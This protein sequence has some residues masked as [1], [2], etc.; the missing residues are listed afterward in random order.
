[1]RKKGKIALICCVAAVPLILIAAFLLLVLPYINA[2]SSM[3]EGASLSLLRVQSGDY[4][5]SW[6]E[7]EGAAYYGVSLGGEDDNSEPTAESHTLLAGL[8]ESECTITVTPYGSYYIFGKE[9]L[10]AGTPLT[11]TVS[12]KSPKSPAVEWCA[13]VDAQTLTANVEPLVGLAYELRLVEGGAD[14]E[15]EDERVLATSSDGE[16]TAFFGEGGL[17]MPEYGQKYSF[18]VRAVVSGSGYSIT[19][20][21]SEVY[22]LEREDLLPDTTE[23]S[24][25]SVGTNQYRLT[26]TEAKGDYYEVQQ[27]SGGEWTAI[28]RLE[29]TDE[30]VY[31]TG[32]LG[33]CREYS[34][35]VVGFDEETQTQPDE[36]GQEPVSE[37]DAYTLTTERSSLYCTIWPL[38]ELAVYA[39]S[40]MAEKLEGYTAPA[41]TAYCVLAEENGM[42][43]V[44]VDDGVYGW[45]DSNY[46]LINLPDYLGDM[47]AYDITNSYASKYMVHG[48]EIPEVTDTVISG[49]EH[50]RLAEGVY[51]A[52]YLYPCCEKLYNAA[53][54]VLADGYRLKIYDSYRPRMA[55]RY[56]FDTTEAI[57]D[58][59]LPETDFYGNVPEDLPDEENLTYRRLVTEGSY[60]LP[61]FLAQNGSMHNMGIALD[62]T[63]E[64]LDT[65]EEL[66]MQTDMHDLSVY[67]IISRNNENAYLLDSYM[68]AAGFG[69]LTSEW[70]HFQDNE[71]RQALGLNT[72]MQYGVSYACWVSDDTGWRYRYADGSYAYGVVT[73]GGS[74]YYFDDAGYYIYWNAE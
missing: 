3:P 59:P 61:N 15:G 36:D 4:V 27:L 19:G 74:E 60:S 39:D 34:F 69:G 38:M 52:P 2:A 1:M 41:A 45:I 5:L 33:S 35:R 67:S 32:T 70:W 47:L 31:E 14:I 30:L 13:D 64:R 6:P 73:I 17:E 9:H 57:I 8:E 68:K 44:R 65:G 42:F 23:I 51:L 53:T 11:V 18:V 26:W 56:I 28:A 62:L 50:V 63:L 55:T 10:R 48:Y 20:L 54:A 16:L 46:C 72:Y 40:G 7:A 21:A 22:A 29:C 49:Y 12:V 25:E 37:S 58:E 24:C 71:T 66:T 43:R